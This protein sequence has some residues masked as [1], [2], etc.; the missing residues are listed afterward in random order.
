MISL[1][2]AMYGGESMSFEV[3]L[4]N[5]VYTVIGNSSNLEGLNVTFDNG[6]ITI[7]PAINY[8]ADNFTIIFFDN[9]TNEVIKEVHTNSHS[10]GR[11]KYVNRNVTVYVP[12]YINNTE[13]VEVEKIIDD[14]KTVVVNKSYKLWQVLVGL[15][16]GMGFGWLIFRKEKYDL[17]DMSN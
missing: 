12:E 2:S 15:V 17:E 4:T 10:S 16:G 6:N 8:K 14:T 5:P 13:I 1:G 11:T 3:D 7:S 9:L